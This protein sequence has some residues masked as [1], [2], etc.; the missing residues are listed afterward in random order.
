[1]IFLRLC[2]WWWWLLWL[3]IIR[4]YESIYILFWFK[5]SRVTCFGPSFHGD[6]YTTSFISTTR[7]CSITY[8]VDIIMYNA[9]LS[10]PSMSINT[11]SYTMILMV[12]I[13]LRLIY[14]YYDTCDLDPCLL[15][16]PLVITS[17][18]YNDTTIM[19]IIFQHIDWCSIWYWCHRIL[20]IMTL[21]TIYFYQVHLL[22]SSLTSWS[23]INNNDHSVNLCCLKRR[24]L[25]ISFDPSQSTSIESL[26]HDDCVLF[27]SFKINNYWIM[28]IIFW[29]NCLTR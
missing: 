27:I 15:R 26:I 25:W 24:L 17:I 2:C 21:E 11:L 6:D 7:L 10:L 12:I 20:I 14:C 1:M 3:H 9:S 4:P 18:S 29:S 16:I 19:I 5:S 22:V 13:I 28:I 23:N 8:R